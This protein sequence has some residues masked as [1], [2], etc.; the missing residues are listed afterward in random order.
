M[1]KLDQWK[2]SLEATKWLKET[3]ETPMGKFFLDVLEERHPLR[4]NVSMPPGFFTANGT[5]ISSSVAG[6][7]QAIRNIRSLTDSTISEKPL[8]ETYGVTTPAH[9]TE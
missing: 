7:E 1:T 6:Y 3:L 9:A 8:M 5:A 4:L 2:A